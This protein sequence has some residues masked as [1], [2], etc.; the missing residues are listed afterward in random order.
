[1]Q[2]WCHQT[3]LV[4]LSPPRQHIHSLGARPRS[5]IYLKPAHALL[6]SNNSAQLP[7]IP[8]P[9]SPPLHTFQSTSVHRCIFILLLI[10]RRACQIINRD[11]LFIPW[12]IFP[13]LCLRSTGEDNAIEMSS[14]RWRRPGRKG[15]R[16]GGYV[17]G[18]VWGFASTAGRMGTGDSCD[19]TNAPITF[20]VNE[21]EE[22]LIKETK[23]ESDTYEGTR[24]PGHNSQCI[25]FDNQTQFTQKSRPHA[26]C[27]RADMLTHVIKC[28]LTRA[29]KLHRMRL[30]PEKR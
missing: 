26:N 15:G 25:T 8:S 29:A 7:I 22:A 6:L 18:K 1:M 12:V 2:A 9:P 30:Y 14:C 21:K 5:Y 4:N 19:I 13:Y 20:S 28:T 3:A 10:C 23:L 17:V 11:E 16:V 27:S 24:G